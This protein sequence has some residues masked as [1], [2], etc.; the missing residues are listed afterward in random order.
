VRNSRLEVTVTKF[1]TE[2]RY[3]GPYEVVRRTP[4]GSYVLKE[5]DGSEHADRYAAFRLLPYIK[6]SDKFLQDSYLSN[7]SDSD[8][9]ESNNENDSDHNTE[10]DSESDQ[11]QQS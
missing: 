3:L 4:G 2:P 6:R 11:E 5:L 10:E 8:N 9:H 7:G 1:K